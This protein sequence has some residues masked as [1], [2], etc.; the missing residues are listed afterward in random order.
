[1]NSECATS[2]RLADRSG[3]EPKF[4]WLCPAKVNLHLQVLGRRE[5][6]YHDLL[7]LMQPLSLADELTVIL[8]PK[9]GITLSSDGAEVPQGK[10]NLVWRAAEKFREASGLDLGLCLSLTKRIPV[11]AG[12]GGGSSDAAGT[13]LA[14]NM[15]AGGPLSDAALYHLGCQLG[16]DV[17]FFLKPGP[18]I[19]RGIGTD[20]QPVALP[21]YWY[22]LVNPGL[23]IST[24]W[25]YE[26]LDLSCL[27]RE[28]RQIG[29]AWDWDRPAAWV[30]NDLESVTFRHFPQ[31]KEYVQ[32]LARL[33]ALAQGMSGSG[34]TIFGLFPSWQEARK[35][36]VEL[37]QSFSG[38][39]V[40]ARGLTGEESPDS[41]ENQVWMI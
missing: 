1:M 14:L 17:P 20:L 15:A 36:A 19:G 41:W 31:L 16:A 38:W 35:A 27:N 23:A 32:A 29:K 22:V 5:D 39:L 11:A 33:G 28:N 37:R 13:L 3:G 24:K 18:K 2:R 6:G 12:L 25:V 4:R 8:S 10:E 40:V 9:G 30:V 7:T 21:P 34:P 26:N